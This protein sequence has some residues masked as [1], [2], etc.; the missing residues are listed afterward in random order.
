MTAGLP[1]NGVLSVTEEAWSVA[2]WQGHLP[3]IGSNLPPA[4]KGPGAR[5]REAGSLRL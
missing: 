1:V 2:K 3:P 5:K 4:M